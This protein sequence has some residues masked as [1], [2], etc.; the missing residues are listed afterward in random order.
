MSSIPKN[1]QIPK[2]QGQFARLQDGK[3]RY[4]VLSDIVTGW[5]G[6]KD[7]KP[8]RHGG[9]VCRIKPEQVDENRDGRPNINYFWGIA[10]YDVANQS[11]K[12]LQITQRTIMAAMKNFEDSPDW[13]DLKG[14]DI[15]I[16]KLKAG[17]K[18]S[19]T[20][21]A[22]PPKPLSDDVRKLYSET[23]V[24]LDAIFAGKYPMDGG[25]ETKADGIPFS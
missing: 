4:R 11:I 6:W 13:G 16:I 9:D 2:S 7:N 17:D 18:I 19:Y 21:V 10:V 15:E 14:Y 20:V 23:K 1:V 8:F 3:N 12:V 25:S 5:E 22:I 24:D